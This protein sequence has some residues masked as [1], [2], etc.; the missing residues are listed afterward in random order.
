MKLRLEEWSMYRWRRTWERG[1]N[2]KGLCF[3][4]ENKRSC[5]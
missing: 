1:R 3:V 4:N 5:W 2:K